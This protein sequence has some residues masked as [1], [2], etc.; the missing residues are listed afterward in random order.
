[1]GHSMSRKGGVPPDKRLQAPPSDIEAERGVLGALFIRP[2]AWA[3]VSN[4]LKPSDFYREA[5]AHICEALFSLKEKADLQTV[6]DWLAER[7]HLEKVGGHDYLFDLTES[8]SHSRGI[9]HHAIIVKKHAERRQIIFLCRQTVEEAYRSMPE[10]DVSEIEDRNLRLMSELKSGVRAI[11][12]DREPDYEP[13]HKIAA[14][15]V[16]E[17]YARA[18][19][20]KRVGVFIGF[21]K[22]DEN[23]QG[24]ADQCTYCLEGESQSGKSS[25]SLQISDNV[26]TARPQKSVL[27]YSLESTVDLL[28]DRMV[29]RRSNINLSRLRVGDFKSEQEDERVI[30]A[31]NQLPNNLLLFDHERFQTWEVLS[32][33]A[34]TR[35]MERP[36]SLIVID[37]LQLLDSLHRF[38]NRH[39]EISYIVKKIN[40]LAKRLS[41]PVLVVSQVNKEGQAKESRDIYNSADYVLH[42]D[43]DEQDDLVKVECK[44][45]RDTGTWETELIFNRFVMEWRESHG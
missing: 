33:H 43:R 34:E 41:C 25:F 24:L 32:A 38:Q 1:M 31:C 20:G 13:T 16:D 7:G 18:K 30:E 40:F 36:L 10:N 44:K 39:L 29:S 9:R 4:L 22:L 37:Y 2:Q 21:E 12:A 5:H 19:E 26:A 27:Y 35:A 28:T 6:G 3:E 45:G 11:E 17:Y 42:L 8:V 14:R 23:L 15:R